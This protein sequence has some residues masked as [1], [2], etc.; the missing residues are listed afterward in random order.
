MEHFNDSFAVRGRG[1]T[2]HPGMSGIEG[3]ILFSM[4]KMNTIS[5]SAS[6]EVARIGAGSSWGEVFSTL[7][8]QGV[9]VTGGTLSVVGVPGLLTGS[10]PP[11]LLSNWLTFQ[12]AN[13]LL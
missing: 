6:R 3:G 7:E 5:L 11:S 1:H 9:A 13:M 2:S 12:Y 10:M 4:E 8:S